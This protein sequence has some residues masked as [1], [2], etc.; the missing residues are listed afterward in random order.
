M[1][2]SGVDHRSGIGRGVQMPQIDAPGVPR[3]VAL[4]SVLLLLGLWWAIAA[5]LGDPRHAPGP[6]LVLPRLWEGIVTGT[7]LPDL[8]ATLGR[9]VI[10]FAIAM[11]IGTALGLLLGV[12]P[13]LDRWFDPWLTIALNIPALVTIVLC[14]LWI[15]LNETAA[16]AA[17]AINKIPMVAVMLREGA[18]AR[19]P[20]LGDLA[21]LHQMSALARLR[22]IL[23]PQLAPHLSAAAR[24]GIAL[25]WKIVL[26]VEFLGR[27]NG[28]GFRIHLD[29]QVF[30]IAGVLAHALAFVA[31]MLAVEWLLLA[32]LARRANRWRQ[33]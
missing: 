28:I 4:V 18:R 20:A 32:P 11:G 22:H 1:R 24:A 15:G 9:V 3:P 7:M 23:L 17:V 16:I 12:M 33:P 6:D 5:W 10:A 26:V 13:A 8:G 2:L 29:F 19:D 14:Y 31:I 25:I 27:S 30:D 21:R